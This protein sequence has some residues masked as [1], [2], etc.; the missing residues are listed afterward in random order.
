MRDRC[1]YIAAV[2]GERKKKEREKK[3]KNLVLLVISS[4][5]GGEKSRKGESRDFATAYT[6]YRRMEAGGKPSS[7]RWEG[8]T[9]L[10]KA[11]LTTAPRHRKG[12]R[13]KKGSIPFSIA[14]PRK[15]GKKRGEGRSGL[16][17]RCRF[18]RRLPHRR[19]KEKG[20]KHRAIFV[21]LSERVRRRPEG[22]RGG[23]RASSSLFHRGDGK[24]K[25]EKKKKLSFSYSR[26]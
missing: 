11:S 14:L 17:K 15:K 4:R 12:K 23:R 1:L 10:V 25:K 19:E 16:A 26:S 21:L 13:R 18:W 3:E 5:G 6:P 24:M 7:I 22:G 20:K 8:G 2:R 9:R